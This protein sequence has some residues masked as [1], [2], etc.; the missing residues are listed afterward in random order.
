MVD[1]QLKSRISIRGI[2]RIDGESVKDMSVTARPSLKFLWSLDPVAQAFLASIPPPTSLTPAS[3]DFV[4]WVDPALLGTPGF[5]DLT[6]EA[7]EG[8]NAPTFTIPRDRD[9]S[10]RHAAPE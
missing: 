1:K 4:L 9:P 3:G 10:P 5:Y 2:V 8:S 6:F 7:A